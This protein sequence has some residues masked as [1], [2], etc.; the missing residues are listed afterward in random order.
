MA[1][2]RLALVRKA[3]A[4]RAIKARAIKV[5]ALKA[6]RAMRAVKASGRRMVRCEDAANVDTRHQRNIAGQRQHR[7]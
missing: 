3:M 7:G 1:G 6:A 4:K 2:F 5:H